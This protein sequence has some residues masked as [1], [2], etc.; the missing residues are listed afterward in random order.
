MALATSR[1]NLLLLEEKPVVL[2]IEDLVVLG[3]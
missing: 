3:G 2:H 1:P